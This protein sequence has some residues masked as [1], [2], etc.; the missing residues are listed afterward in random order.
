[1][2]S[3]LMLIAAGLAIGPAPVKGRVIAQARRRTWRGSAVFVGVFVAVLVFMAVGRLSV[4]VAALSVGV[5]V[6]WV[7]ADAV[8]RRRQRREEAAVA[9]FLGTV[10]A[11]LR[12]GTA[13]PQALERGVDLLDAA[14]PAL[15]AALR[16]AAVMAARGGSMAAA[17]TQHPALEEV[18]GLCAVADE[19]GIGLAQLLD[20][21]QSRLDTRQR[22]RQATAA[23]LQGP[24]STAVVLTCLPLAGIGMGA[25][26]GANPVAFL[27]GGGLGGIL[28]M[29]GVGLSCAGFVWSR[30]ILTKATG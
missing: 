17:L 19:H 1:M 5:C 7:W 12:A 9:S 16:T 22:H 15:E 11:D 20:Q 3:G 18:A 6:S 8:R 28:L 23:S 21:A 29:V 25:M 10:T 24:Q 14:P 13:L 30:Q 2:T 4:A 26:M 27:F